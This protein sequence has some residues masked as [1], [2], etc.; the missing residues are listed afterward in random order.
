MLVEHCVWCGVVLLCPSSSPCVCC[1]VFCGF[2]APVC[3]YAIPEGISI[4]CATLIGNALGAS[5]AEEAKRVVRIGLILESMYGLLNGLLF[6]IVLRSVW[7]TAF[8][9]DQAVLDLC[10]DILP[11]MYFYSLFD[12]T[13]C[14]MMG[15]LRGAGMNIILFL[16]FQCWLV[17]TA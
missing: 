3:R 9:N 2:L 16:F 6:T 15:I 8:S 10:Y 5:D 17:T 7:G 1:C 13:K 4:G 11:I 12:A 14:A